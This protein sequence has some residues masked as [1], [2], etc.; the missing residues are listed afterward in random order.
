LAA[1]FTKR[2]QLYKRNYKGLIVEVLIPVLLVL[3][4]FAFSKVQFFFNSPERILRPSEFPLKQRIVVNQ[5]LM[6][7]SGNDFAIRD[8]IQSLPSYGSSF[9][10]RYVDYSGISVSG[11]DG[12]TAVLKAFDNDVFES[13]LIQPYEPFRYGSYFIYEANK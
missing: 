6:K 3:I 4:G 8:I 7:T 13:R 11:D 10:A 5:N 12:E 2:L 9:D 1:L